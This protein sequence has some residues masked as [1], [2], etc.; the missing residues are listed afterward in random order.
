GI[1]DARTDAIPGECAVD[2]DCDGGYCEC[3]DARCSALQCVPGPCDCRWGEDC[4]SPLDDGVRD[5]N[6]CS[7]QQACFGGVCYP[8]V[9]PPAPPSFPDVIGTLTVVV[10]TEDIL[11]ADT[12]DEV[13]LCLS[14]S[15]C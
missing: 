1:H 9:S 14:A 2:A 5:P 11:A 12:S 7:G 3:A 13:T 4:A 8:H 6:S 15:R 10:R